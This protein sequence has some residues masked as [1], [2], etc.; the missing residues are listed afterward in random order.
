M[1][2]LRFVIDSRG[3]V[4]AVARAGQVWTR[5]GITAG[6]M[7]ERLRAFSGIVAEYGVR[8]SFPITAAVLDR[9]PQVAHMLS[10][11]GVELCVHGLVHNDLSELDPAEQVR[12][13]DQAAGIFRKHGIGFAGFRSPYLKYN[14]ATLKAVENAGFEY[15]SNL[16]FYWG[17][18]EGLEHLSPRQ[19]EGLDRGLRFYNPV[20]RPEERSL[21]RHVGG[22]V[23]IPVSLPDDEILLDRMG[24]PAEAIAG[25]WRRM[26]AMALERGELL[27]LQ[28]HPERVFLLE[29][30]LRA[31]LD[32]AVSTRAFWMTTLAEIA[33]WWRQR[34]G[35]GSTW[36]EPYRAALAVTGDIDCLTLGDFVRRFREG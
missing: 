27:T 7:Q 11:L 36:P 17:P 13:I 15:D 2:R 35:G 30:C 31:V 32:F 33:R 23:E 26:A 28:L 25:V 21:P 18:A 22:L 5:F 12:Q 34:E 16:P 6:R 20:S 3:W 9:N 24:L 10:G 14:G 29:P 19:A 4:N 1:N 8:P